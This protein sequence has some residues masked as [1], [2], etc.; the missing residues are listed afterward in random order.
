MCGGSGMYIQAVLQNFQL[1]NIPKN[2]RLRTRLETF[3]LNEL[4]KELEHYPVSS[5]YSSNPSSKRQLIRAIETSLWKSQNPKTTQEKLAS[6]I[7]HLIFGLAPQADA[8]RKRISLRLKNRLEQGLIKEVE[9]L[10]AIGISPEQLIYYGLEYKW[11]TL[12]LQNEISYEEFFN[13][14]EVAIHQFSKRQMTYFRKMEKD[15]LSVEWLNDESGNRRA[16]QLYTAETKGFPQPVALIS[17]P[18]FNVSQSQH[19]YFH[20]FNC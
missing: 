18:L 15:G 6:S 14:L 19:T 16:A 17:T 1:T 3:S 8:R 7:P 13:K 10:L 4:K 9:N 20:S 12:Y 11:A 5:S 2:E